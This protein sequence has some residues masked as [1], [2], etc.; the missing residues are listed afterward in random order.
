MCSTWA[1]GL[2]SYNRQDQV[3]GSA[4]IKGEVGW[5]SYAE[6][7]NEEEDNEKRKMLLKS[8]VFTNNDRRGL[9]ATGEENYNVEI[10]SVDRNMTSHG[11]VSADG[12]KITMMNG[13]IYEYMDEEAI[14]QMKANR[15][16]ADNPPNNYEP[17]P[18]GQILW[19]SGM[20]GM[21]KSTTAK[22]LQEKEGFV[23]YEGDCFIMGYNP[24]VGAA[25]KGPSYFGTRPL[26]GI[27]EE[28]KT[29]CKQAID[30]GYMN[31]VLKGKPVDPKIW[32]DFYT[33]LCEDILKER[34]KIGGRWVVN[35][36]VYT[37]A[38]REVVR[39][40]LG[41]YLTMVVLVSEDTD[42]QKERLSKRA[43]G[44]GEVGKEAKKE[45]DETMQRQTGGAEEVDNTER[46]TLEVKVSKAMSPED[47]ADLVL[48][49][50]K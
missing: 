36:A 41:D 1:D 20:A 6:P 39:E 33:L 8:G 18:K 35:Q 26:T 49:L 12:R 46:N 45:A 9:D 21:G 48:N 4:N 40:K 10:F 44:E 42:L 29:V 14:K 50:V 15:D 19:I 31:G 30:K 17:R 16:P 23:N 11:V 2:Y 3:I 34:E 43:L 24:Y 37:K 38:A 28:R 32:E 13:Y 25:P 5:S 27:T 47:V 7:G 22:L